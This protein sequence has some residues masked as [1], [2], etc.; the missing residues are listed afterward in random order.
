MIQY[1]YL[2]SSLYMLDDSYDT[3]RAGEAQTGQDA[4][5]SVQLIIQQSIQES[6]KQKNPSRNTLSLDHVH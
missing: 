1:L 3:W 2:P 5:G 6:G 4:G